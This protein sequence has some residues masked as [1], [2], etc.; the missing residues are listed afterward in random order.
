LARRTTRDASLQT[1]ATVRFLVDRDLRLDAYRA[2][3]YFRWLDDR[4]DGAGMDQGERLALVASQQALV[5]R[6]YQGDPP[7]QA[8]GE[9][10]M[11][12][13]LIH[14]HPQ[15]DGLQA[16]IRNL[17]GVMAFDAQR[18]GRL[19]SQAELDHYTGCLATAVTEALHYFI[20]HCCTPPQDQARLLAASAAHVA[21]MLRDT[22]DDVEAGYYNIPGE[23]LETYRIGPQDVT[24]E[25]YRAWVK[26]RV[27]LA[28]AWF[29][30]GYGYLAQVETRR[31]RLAG[32]AYI[33]RFTQVLDSIEKDG[34]RLR[35]AYPE[36]KRWS[37]SLAISWNVLKLALFPRQSG[38]SPIQS[39]S[40][41]GAERRGNPRLLHPG[42]PSGVRNDDLE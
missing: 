31:C 9:E 26:S 14:N 16:Y 30:A 29:N 24:S 23:Y 20:G 40:L 12:V 19:V 36:C 3:G 42:K 25:P 7:A 4:L 21:H 13:D 11:L 28:R 32:Y 1:Y 38:I 27:R 5:E 41:R 22:F 37:A 15:N 39:L 34:Y 2:Y 17:M 8:T 6:C 18:R 33:G 10:S 35:R